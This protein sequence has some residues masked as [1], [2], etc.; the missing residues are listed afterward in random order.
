MAAID[1]PKA[2]VV[3]HSMGGAVAS[4]LALAHPDRVASLTLIASAGL[5]AEINVGYTGGFAAAGSRRDLKPLLEQL[6]NDG[7]LVSRQM[8]DDVLKYK[9]LDGVDALLTELNAGLFNGGSQSEQ[10][11]LKLG[12]TGK[13][14]LVV[15]GREDRIVP[16]SHAGNAPAGATVE[17]FEGAGHMVQLERA[18]DVNALIKRHVGV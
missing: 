7:S 15:W 4:Q 6:F 17:I 18:N 2:H 8:I 10:P 13:P 16:A 14:V 3:G 11:G 1:L 9:R 5:G 12:S